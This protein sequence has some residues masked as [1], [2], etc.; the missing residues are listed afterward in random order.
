VSSVGIIGT[1]TP[2]GWDN[3]TPMSLVDSASQTYAIELSLTAGECKFRANNAWD[4]N[5]GDKFFPFGTGTQ[6]GPNIPVSLAGNYRITLSAVSGLYIFDYLGSNIG[7]I[8][9]ATPRGWDADVNMLP[10]GA[11]TSK[12]ILTGS[13]K[14]GEMKFRANDGWDINWGASD[15]PSGV[16][17]Q[18][19]PNIPIPSAGNYEI[20]FD[21][22]TGAYSLKELVAFKSI[23]IIGSATPKGWDQETALTKDANNPDLWR[24]VVALVAGEFKFRADSAWAINWGGGSFPNDTASF[25]GSNIAI[26]ADQAGEYQVS[27]DTKSAIY[28]FLKIEDYNTV[29]IIGNA[30][31]AGWDNSTPMIKDPNDKS[32]WKIRAMLVEGEMKFRANDAWDVNWGGDGFPSGTGF[33]DGPNIVIAVAGDYKIAFNSTTGAYSFE[34]VEEFGKISIVGKSGPFGDWP[35][36][37]D[38]RDTYMTK[39]PNDGNHWTLASITLTDFAGAT[40]A[41]IKFRAEA[42]WAINWGDKAFPGGVGTQNGPNIE[43]TAGTFK[44]DFKSD[45][46]EYSFSPAGSNTYNLLDD[47]SLSI[48]P[49]PAS[50]YIEIKADLAAINGSVA[51]TILDGQGRQISKQ[52]IDLQNTNKVSVETLP[53]GQYFLTITSDKYLVARRFVVA[54]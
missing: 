49:N 42:A 9:S 17:T 31:P 15:F 18:G 21:K 50:Q 22:T 12:F 5:W 4:I 44:V 37:D 11:D 51:V 2:G 41:G 45:T 26:G 32:I 24:G 29:G 54:K 43:C 19:G 10:D 40:D 25:N 20:K 48:Q 13:L 6:G 38:S 33:Q 27:F 52:Q 39:D 14:M 8:G 35:G 36:A 16:G 7:I 34:K 1:A 53:A 46:G 3:E 23:G 47:A 30:T 28:K